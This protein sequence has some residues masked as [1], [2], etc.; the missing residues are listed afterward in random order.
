MAET[1]WSELHHTNLKILP[2]E[3]MLKPGGTTMLI[4]CRLMGQNVKVIPPELRQVCFDEEYV[5][6]RI[7]GMLCQLPDYD[8]VQ[9]LIG[10]LDK[11]NNGE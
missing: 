7:E 11:L 10:L 4:N 5:Y 6:Y 2:N 9:I 1:H 8:K 3:L